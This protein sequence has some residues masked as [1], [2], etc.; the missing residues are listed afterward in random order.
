MRKRV[1]HVHCSC[2]DSKVCNNVRSGNKKLQARQSTILPFAKSIK[3][4]PNRLKHNSL[5]TPVA[6][7]NHQQQQTISN[8]MSSSL[9]AA[10]KRV[11]HKERSQP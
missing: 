3:A 6:A 7:A 10:L 2:R 4:T 11:T 5:H 8:S 9:K 1:W